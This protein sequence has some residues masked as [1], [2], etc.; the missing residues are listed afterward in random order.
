MSGKKILFSTDYFEARQ[1][2]AYD[3]MDQHI[4]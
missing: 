3:E 1:H 4:P 2:E